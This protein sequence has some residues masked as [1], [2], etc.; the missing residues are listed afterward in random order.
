MRTKQTPVGIDFSELL[1]AQKRLD[2]SIARRAELLKEVAK[3][4]TRASD[5]RAKA[6]ENL[7]AQG[8]PLVAI[9]RRIGVSQQAL[10]KTLARARE[11]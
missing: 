3:D 8:V 9:A 7:R 5:A 2:E 11:R 4:I 10:S 1:E 6:I